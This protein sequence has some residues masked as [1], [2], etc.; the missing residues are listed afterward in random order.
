MNKHDSHKKA[1]QLLDQGD[2]NSLLLANLLLRRCVEFIVY[3]KLSTYKKYVPGVVFDKWQPSHALKTLLQFEPDADQPIRLRFAK[4]D[5]QGNPTGPWMDLGEHRT[6]NHSWLNKNYNKLS[7]YLHV[8]HGKQK[9]PEKTKYYEYLSSVSEEIEKVLEC[10]LHGCSIAHRIKY[11]CTVC[12]MSS[13]VH[14]DIA[15]KTRKAI[16]INP[17]CG[18]IH[19]VAFNDDSWE[20]VLEATN[21]PCLKCNAANLLENR[22]IDIGTTFNCIECD[23]KHIIGTRNWGYAIEDE[24]NKRNS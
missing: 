19:L 3:D 9:Q 20:V 7:S 23:T 11:K 22:H 10:R 17:N 8:P 15:E 18:A 21:I 6:L 16:C 12:G 13:M 14:R 24:I 2:E 4:E 5:T 1:K